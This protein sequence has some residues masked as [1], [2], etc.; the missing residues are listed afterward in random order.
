MS[1]L[2]AWHLPE[3]GLLLVAVL[4]S[5]KAPQQ[6]LKSWP[7]LSAEMSTLTCP[8]YY[9]EQHVSQLPADSPRLAQLQELLALTWGLH[10]LF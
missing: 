8:G 7:G 1:T 4:H 9:R 6:L 10:L 5:P 2:S 3:P